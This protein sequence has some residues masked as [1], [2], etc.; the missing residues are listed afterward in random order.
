[1]EGNEVA[2][3]FI[4]VRRILTNLGP[5]LSAYKLLLMMASS[6]RPEMRGVCLALLRPF[7][8]DGEVRVKYRCGKR[9]Y[10]AC[11]GMA[12]MNSDMVSVMELGVRC[13]YHLDPALEPQVV[14]DGGGNIGMFTL[15]AAATYPQARIVVCEPVPRNL[16]QIEKH[17]GMNNVK[18]E[19]RAICIGGTRRTLPFYVREANQSSFT[20]DQPY[21][22]VMELE[23]AP[24]R[25]IMQ[26]FD[27]E[28]L[29]VK[30]D[31]E[32]MEM[33]ALE[34]YVPEEKRA[35]CIVGELHG[36]K[37]NASFIERLFGENGWTVKFDDVS[38]A[39]SLFEAW[40]PA[41]LEHIGQ[42]ATKPAAA[43]ARS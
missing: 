41:A 35:V 32:G 3:G 37:Q 31:I 25:E 33:E 38:D 21:K 8:K 40:S 11:I 13:V 15:R 23:V 43:E 2:V 42:G 7:V 29:L 27:A 20:P 9:R 26:G 39:G 4:N 36:H 16:K 12:D 30:L 19:V 6:S 17:L 22:R 14:L 34:S 18:A 24:L 5:T 10:T 28:R 1:M